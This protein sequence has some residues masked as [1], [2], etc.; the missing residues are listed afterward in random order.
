MT[1]EERWQSA[2]SLKKVANTIYLIN[3]AILVSIF[4]IKCGHSKKIQQT[5]SEFTSN[6]SIKS[7]GGANVRQLP[8][9]TSTVITKV[10]NND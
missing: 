5:N 10:G 8:S 7:V 2:K 9:L 4:L 6:A 1:T 3:L